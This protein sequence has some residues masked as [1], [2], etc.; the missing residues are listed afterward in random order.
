[1][2]TAFRVTSSFE[3]SLTAGT[4]SGLGSAALVA[5]FVVDSD[6]RQESAKQQSPHREYASKLLVAHCRFSDLV[7]LD[8][9]ELIFLDLY[10]GLCL[11]LQILHVIDTHHSAI[12]TD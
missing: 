4:R 9:K 2:L 3:N 12:P 6:L 1:M 5:E 11:S 7:W 8:P 10:Y